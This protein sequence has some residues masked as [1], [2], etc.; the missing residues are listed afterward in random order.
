ME[1]AQDSGTALTVGVFLAAGLLVW[2]ELPALAFL[3]MFLGWAAVHRAGSPP[4]LIRIAAVASV[5]LAIGILAGALG[6]TVQ[7]GSGA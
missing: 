7:A 6:A 3:G 4:R 5:L 1:E 2:F